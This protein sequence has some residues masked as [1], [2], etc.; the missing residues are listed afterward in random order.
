METNQHVLGPDA[1]IERSVRKTG[2]ILAA[3]SVVIVVGNEGCQRLVARGWIDSH[4]LFGYLSD[5]FAV[6]CTVGLSNALGTSR[7]YW[8]RP[9]LFGVLFSFLEL[10]G[11]FD[12]W[13]FACYWSGA[14]L[15]WGVML[16]VAR[17][18]PQGE[19]TP[20]VGSDGAE[21]RWG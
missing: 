18:R 19:G 11:V 5:L 1:G 3:V 15:S 13:D 17:S 4:W 9:V 12:P 20:A 10:E 2:A 21:D 7:L 14:L 6:P 8:F 16:R